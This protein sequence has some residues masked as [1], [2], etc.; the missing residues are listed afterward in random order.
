MWYKAYQIEQQYGNTQSLLKLFERGQNSK[1]DFLKLLH[2][3][4]LWKQLDK[5]MEALDLLSKQ[6]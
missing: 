6:E 2:A 1:H 4:L 3:K 5:P